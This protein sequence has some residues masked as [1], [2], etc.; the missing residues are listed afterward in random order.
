MKF[1]SPVSSST[2]TLDPEIQFLLSRSPV[3][4]GAILA[5]V[6]SPTRLLNQFSAGDLS[7]SVHLYRFGTFELDPHSAELRRQGLKIKLQKKSFQLLLI[8]L[9]RAGNVVARE[10]L[11]AGLWPADT[12]VDFDANIKTAL[13]RLRQSLGDPAEHPIFI[14]TV[15]KAGFRFIAPVIRVAGVGGIDGIDTAER[16]AAAEEG[17]TSAVEYPGARFGWSRASGSAAVVAVVAVV[18]IA[19]FVLRRSSTSEPSSSRPVV[20]LVLPF[21]NLSG[22]PSQQYF[23]DGVTDE[24]IA[25]LGQQAPR[26]LSVIARASAM[27]YRGTH[28]PLSQV[29]RELGG[30]DYILEGSVRRSGSHVAINTEL[31]RIPDHS[32]LWAQSYESEV[33]DVLVLQQDVAEKVSHSL[34]EKLVLTSRAHARVAPNPRA[35]D[36]FLMGLYY[37][38][39]KRTNENMLKA[40]KYFQEAIHQDPDYAE[41]YAGL[42]YVYMLA[43]GWELIEPAD[44]Y[45]KAKAAAE[46]ALQLDPNLAEAHMTLAAVEHEYY[47][48]W[49]EAETEF[50]RA[51]ELNP[52][53]SL[54]HKGYAEFLV[55]AGRNEEA[56]DEV[57]RAVSL[58]PLALGVRVFRAF[59]YL[60]AKRYDQAI[61][62]CKA[63]IEIDPQ[64]YSAYYLLGGV[65]QVVG[66]Y[67]DAIA[68]F[69]AAQQFSAG[70]PKMLAALA[71]TY[72]LAGQRED[73]LRLLSIVEQHKKQRYISPYSLA[74]I[75][76]GLGDK[77]RAFD[78][79]AKA[80]RERSSDLMYLRH[81]PGLENLHEDPRFA[82]LV[83]KIGF[84]PEANG[85]SQIN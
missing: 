66:Q 75:Y 3:P 32:V 68:Q 74:T 84:P 51:I 15:P 54:A 12:F 55:H 40:L 85:R 35:H 10:E 7:A 16:G 79:L 41:P 38:Q 52:N 61:H 37:Q 30:V 60:Y 39:N 9:E 23:S 20:L 64:F 71:R 70:S 65:Y 33:A 59:V 62:E 4:I 19:V 77:G 11:R 17:S 50:R 56:V 72:A 63:V 57:E 44:A 13:N 73:A 8:L 48:K 27:Q 45:P 53:S 28:K 49:S 80:T 43:A 6:A 1:G 26:Q 5:T 22:D 29:A 82:E 2:V 21:D 47:W 58:D 31:S 81:E 69:Q 76:A 25:S 83:S 14:E 42:A 18:A 78:L 67:T 34:V 24:M 36:A 46:R